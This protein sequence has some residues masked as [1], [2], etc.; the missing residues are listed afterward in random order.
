MP[1]KITR[2]GFWG[3]SFA[4]SSSLLLL[5]AAWGDQIA[6]LK[7][8]LRAGLKCRRQVEFDFVDRVVLFV[9]QGRLPKDLVLNTFDWAKK[10]RED[11][12]F[13]YFQQ[14]L[15]LRARKIGVAL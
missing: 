12:P 6:T 15:T 4:L 9:E 14:A 2:R 1:V 5:P 13:P 11:I 8:T 7:D 10:Q 3:T